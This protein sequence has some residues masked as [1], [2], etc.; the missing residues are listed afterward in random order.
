[1]ATERK[2]NG[3]ETG[4]DAQMIRDLARLLDE[5]GLSEIELERE[6]LR[7]RVARNL[8]VQTA[9]PMAAPLPRAAEAPS[10]PALETPGDLAKHLGAVNSPM[11]GTVYVGPEPGAP[12]FV[13]LGDNVAKGQTL[14]LV[15]AMK[16]M[17]PIV[18]PKAGKI[19]RILVENEAPV[20]YGQALI[21]I[22]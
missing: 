15:E 1:M 19:A 10:P 22:E 20:E 5:T 9:V 4:P 6:G 3:F 2:K 17:N 16:T 18:A 7:L 13:K 8:Q 21:I 12:P 14:L 11:V